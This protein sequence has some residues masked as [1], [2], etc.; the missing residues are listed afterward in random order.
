MIELYK[1]L[2]LLI[3]HKKKATKL[4]KFVGKFQFFE[5]FNSILNFYL[6]ALRKDKKHQ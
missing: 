4:H 6:L 2:L 1:F 3:F 5:I